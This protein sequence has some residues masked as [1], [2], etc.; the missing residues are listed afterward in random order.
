MTNSQM[1]A[2]AQ[3]TYNRVGRGTWNIAH[4][5]AVTGISE[6]EL[7]TT[8]DVCHSVY[9]TM[10]RDSIHRIE[11]YGRKVTVSE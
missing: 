4:V 3:C 5:S 2:N 1:R 10:R 7:Q 8:S 6:S 11:V 9:P